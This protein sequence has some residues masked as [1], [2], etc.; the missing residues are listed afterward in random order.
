MATAVDRHVA[1]LRQ[2]IESHHGVLY[3]VVGDAIQA[4]FPTAPDAISAALKGQRAL[5]TEDWGQ[6]GPIRVRMAVHAGEA[7]P[8]PTGDYLTPTLNRLSRLLAAGQGGQILLS[9]TVQ[10]LTRGALP[11]SS[12]LR[13][14][15]EH[16]LRDLLEPER[17]Y[18]LLHPDLPAEFPPLQTL[19]DHP[20]NLPHQPTVLLGRERELGEIE[21]L[22]RREDVQ[23][24]TLTGPGGVG[25]TR[26]ALQAAADLLE[27]FPD[28]AFFVDL[29]PLVDP[30]LVP[31]T[32]ASALGVREEGGRPVLEVL[33]AFLRS[34]RFLL[35]LDNF[36]HLLPA[37]PLVSDLLRTCPGVKI[38]ATS[39]APLHLRGEREYPVPTLAVPDPNRR[40][41]VPE[42]IHYEAVRLFAERAQAAKPDFALTDENA[43]AVVEICRRLDG[44]PLAIELAAARIKLLPPQ[45]LLERLG[46][47]LKVLTGGARDAPARQQ[48][49]RDAIA[50]SHDL[51]SSH[52]QTL[53]RRLA[54]FA[55]GCTLETVEAV[56]IAAGD[57]D[58]LEGM[59]SLV[60]ESL[61]RQAED[62]GGEPRYTLLETVREFSLDRLTVSGEER[63]I[64]SRHAAYF[65]G[66]AESLQ[67]DIDG[68]EQVRT[69]AA[70]GAE[71]DN[72]RAAIAWAIEQLDAETA[73]RLTGNLW[74]FWLVRSRQTEGR[75]WLERSL[76]VPGDAPPN[77]RLEALFAA[78]M[79][80]RQQGD[81]GRAVLHGEEGL[82]FACKRSQF[83]RGAITVLAGAGRTFPRRPGSGAFAL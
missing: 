24:V 13:D 20:H 48:T 62:A 1:L 10:Q 25:K 33:I 74:G 37:S 19:A 17:A 6:I 71:Q 11:A 28:G 32:V 66:L 83:S 26:L 43:A 7:S 60:D 50:W 39:R 65:A 38:L 81:Y 58:I 73:L 3:K 76:A 36:E 51:L 79:F 14:L 69:A 47:H 22:L 27:V 40:E 15:G 9:Q 52:E 46:D 23:L 54:V 8:D 64:R 31:S 78:G 80:A 29:A 30:A 49:L 61:L 34:R 21:A 72:L 59:G 56:A 41:P 42:L 5:L 68:P 67:P 16:R 12:E 57:L 45:A 44:L 53:F 55:G 35:V 63:L 2:A 75:D 18:Q 70:L 82:A 77:T 4:A